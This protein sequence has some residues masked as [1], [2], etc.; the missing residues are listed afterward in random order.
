MRLAD[1]ERL[2]LRH[3]HADFVCVLATSAA[4]VYGRMPGD[5]DRSY[6]HLQMDIGVYLNNQQPSIG[7]TSRSISWYGSG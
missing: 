7:S 2:G 3:F 6:R 4:S 5:G 1:S